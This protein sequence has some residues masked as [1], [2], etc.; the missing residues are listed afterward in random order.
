MGKKLAADSAR[1]NKNTNFKISAHPELVF[2]SPVLCVGL[3]DRAHKKGIFQ[4]ECLNPLP[5]L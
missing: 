4:H 1:T 3:I 2:C 5:C